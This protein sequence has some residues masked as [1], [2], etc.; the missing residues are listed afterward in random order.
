M[1]IIEKHYGA[2]KDCPIC[3]VF[4]YKKEEE[5]DISSS[6]TARYNKLRG[7]NKSTSMFS[8]N[9]QTNIS[10]NKKDFLFTNRNRINSSKKS[11][12]FQENQSS[13]INRNFNILFDYFRQ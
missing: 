11:E 8:I 6:K 7:H 13:Q 10:N 12:N 5:N 1:H 2:E 9:S 3:R 4:I